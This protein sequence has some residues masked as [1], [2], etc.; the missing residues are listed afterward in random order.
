MITASNP[1][2]LSSEPQNSPASAFAIVFVNGDFAPMQC[3]ANPDSLMP[4]SGPAAKM[5]LFSGPSG[6]T[7]AGSSFSK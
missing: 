2:A 3:R 7:R 5:S 4:V 6:S 1:A